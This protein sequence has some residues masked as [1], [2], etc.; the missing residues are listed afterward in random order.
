MSGVCV[1]TLLS[2]R[3]KT[4]GRCQAMFST[5]IPSRQDFLQLLEMAGLD[6]AN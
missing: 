3:A 1:Y 4:R 5:F 2:L 6:M